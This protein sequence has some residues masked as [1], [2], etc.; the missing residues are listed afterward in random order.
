MKKYFLLA[1]VII[2]AFF[3]FLYFRSSQTADISGNESVIL[4][5]GRECPHCLDLE[6]DIEDNK[7]SEKVSFV[8]AEVFHNENNRKIFVE[9]YRFCGIAD[10]K[11][12]GV[13]ML[14][15]DGKCYVGR[16]KIMEFFQNKIGQ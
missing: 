11:E 1:A 8:Q 16:D 4:F 7:I 13:P 15:S 2:M 12:L 14:W 5:Y 9:K 10:E 3:V 6:G